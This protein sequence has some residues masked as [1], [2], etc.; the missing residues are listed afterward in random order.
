MDARASKHVR[1][2]VCMVKR[3]RARARVQMCVY[4]CVCACMRVCA[5]SGLAEG[6]WESSSM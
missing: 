6:L 1:G 3:V 2:E 4:V 5:S